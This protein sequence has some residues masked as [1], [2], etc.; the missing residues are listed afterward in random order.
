MNHGNRRDRQQSLQQAINSGIPPG[1]A[2]LQQSV[3]IN[4]QHQRQAGPLADPVSVQIGEIPNIQMVSFGGITIRE[5]LAGMALAN[6]LLIGGDDISPR[7]IARAAVAVAD[8]VLAI[9]RPAP[10][11]VAEP[12]KRG[13]VDQSEPGNGP[14]VGPAPSPIQLP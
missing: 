1:G 3:P 13:V 6:P 9:T 14:D 12:P 11:A 10:A 7:A 8:E 4:I 2:I 5:Q